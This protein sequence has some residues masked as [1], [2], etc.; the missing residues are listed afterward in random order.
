MLYPIAIELGDEEHAH[1]IIVPDVPVM[2]MTTLLLTS[3]RL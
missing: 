2:T 3:Q 1:G